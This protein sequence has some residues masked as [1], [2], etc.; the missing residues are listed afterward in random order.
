M[1]T[2]IPSATEPVLWDV[3]YSS[4]Y[5]HLPIESNLTKEKAAQLVNYLNGGSGFL[6]VPSK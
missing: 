1:H 3:V 2:L 4:N 5:G 6:F